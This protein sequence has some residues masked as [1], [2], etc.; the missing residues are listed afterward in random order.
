MSLKMWAASC[1]AA[2]ALSG[3]AYFEG[4]DA[5][6]GAS[7][8]APNYAAGSLVAP[9]LTNSDRAALATAFSLALSDVAESARRSWTGPRASGE[10]VAER[11][12]VRNIF[13]D[14]LRATPGV[15]GLDLSHALETDLG[16]YVLKTDA[17]IRLAPSTDGKKTMTLPS[18]ARFTALGRVAQ[19][20]WL[21]VGRDGVA[22]GYVYEPLAG[23]APGRD[24]VLAGGPTRTPALCREY[25]QTAVIGADQDLWRGAACRAGD[26]RWRLAPELVRTDES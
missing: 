5:F 9:M 2:F 18:G 12:L 20:E 19:D 10:V 8:A 17:N 16:A 7:E 26:G 14:P 24:L 22:I 13:N 23:P 6:S 25:T 3:C 1:A 11:F 21:L 15:S 4:G